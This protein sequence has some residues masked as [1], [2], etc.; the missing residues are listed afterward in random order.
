MAERYRAPFSFVEGRWFYAI[1]GVTFGPFAT[2]SR[3]AQEYN[4]HGCTW[5]AE[6]NTTGRSAF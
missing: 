2:E 3:A 6:P 1:D 5:D 4:Y